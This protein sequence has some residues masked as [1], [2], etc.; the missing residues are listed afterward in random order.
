[1]AAYPTT[2]IPAATYS[3]G[4]GYP[5][6]VTRYAAGTEQRVR[7]G[8]APARAWNLAYTVNDAE[9]ATLQ[10]FWDARQGKL[11]A[12]DF[13]DPAAGGASLTARFDQD[14]LDWERIAPGWWRTSVQITE[15]H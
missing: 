10:A 6:A 13:V 11:E 14:R 8:T 12:F 9:K 4:S 7:L 2:P 3:H 15:V 5:V 1:M